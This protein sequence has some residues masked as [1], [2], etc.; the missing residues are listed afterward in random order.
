MN[1]SKKFHSQV[2]FRIMSV[3]LLI[4]ACAANLIAQVD[5]PQTKGVYGG[6]IVYI[7]ALSNGVDQT[8]L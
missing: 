8:R 2:F 6:D 4:T 5:A 7:E 1:A 3:G